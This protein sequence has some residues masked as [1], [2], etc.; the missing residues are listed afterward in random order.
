[1]LK[2]REIDIKEFENI[3]GS[4]NNLLLNSSDP[5][6]F[7]TWE[8]LISYWKTYGKKYRKPII[9]TAEVDHKLVGAIALR[10]DRRYISKTYFDIISFLSQGPSDYNDV[11]LHRE[12]GKH[13]TLYNI[14]N[15]IGSCIEWDLLYM[16]DVPVHSSLSNRE[17]FNQFSLKIKEETK[18]VSY[19]KLPDTWKGFLSTLSANL[20]KNIRSKEKRLKRLGK[21]K[22]ETIN[23][24]SVK[25]FDV[26][27]DL[28]LKRW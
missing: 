7:K 23:S 11:I 10:K 17:L 25:D 27:V 26:F 9:L 16:N 15:Y 3:R 22:F 28:N 20:R 2:I 24:P 18:K 19:I 13:K 1:M 8:W 5:N 4:W 21:V 6:F 14:L 12:A